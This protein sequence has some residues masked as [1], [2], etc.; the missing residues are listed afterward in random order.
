MRTRALLSLLVL[1]ACSAESPAFDFAAASVDAA[2][3]P[4]TDLATRSLNTDFGPLEPIGDLGATFGNL[5]IT[6]DDEDTNAPVPARVIFRPPPGSGFADSLTS[7]TVN[8]LSA[9]SY[10]GSQV[11][12]GV[13][14]SPEG[15]LL[16]NG[17]GVVPVPAGTYQLFI[18]RGPEYEAV[19]RTVTVAAGGAEVVQATLVR[20]VDTRGWLAADMHV[21]TGRSFDSALLPER[22]VISMVTNGVEVVVATDHN[23][24]TDLGPVAAGLGYGADLIGTIVG[25]EFNFA[26]GHGGAYPMPYDATLPGGGAPPYENLVAG[27]CPEPRV[28]INCYPAAIAFPFMHS[29]LLGTSVVTVNHPWW[30]NGD[31][32]YFT[33][34]EWGAGTANPLPARL[35]TAHLFDAIEILNGYQ[36]Y[37]VPENNLLADWFYLLGQGYRVTALGSSDTHKINWVR[38]G[39]PRTWLRLPNDLP[40][41]TTGA[42]LADA[43]RHNRAIASTGP[44]ITMTVDG[45]QIGDQVTPKV[46]GQITIQVNVDAPDWIDVDTLRIYVDGRVRA[47]SSL[48]VGRRPRFAGSFVL[49][50][51]KDAWVVALASGEQELP[52]DVVGESGDYVGHPM[53]PWAITNAIYVDGDGDGFWAPVASAGD[54]PKQRHSHK[55]APGEGCGPF[56]DPA[57]EPPLDTAEHLAMPLLF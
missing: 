1:S 42:A 45:A 14:G 49:P 10:T 46:K 5:L 22:R 2:T 8:P 33:N 31:L 15:V 17:R 7:G 18:T 23:V 27:S 55:S 25:D 43:I 54:W 19:Q 57:G 47:T 52:A 48:P 24:F 28:G 20:S 37:D 4:I 30:A 16:A 29:K 11:S 39:W 56:D 32:G 53:K 44:F 26:E 9:G 40:G 6:V 38:P 51:T 13:I 21:H 3:P 12:P 41:E 50:I 36:S 35:E 34:I